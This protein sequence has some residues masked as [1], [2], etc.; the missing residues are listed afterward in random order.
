MLNPRHTVAPPWHDFT[1]LWG[2]CRGGGMGAMSWP[3]AGG[4][5]DQAA[6]IV[7]AFAILASLD[8]QLDRHKRE[9]GGT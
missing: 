2:M 7:D 9:M 8:A 3:D 4:V 5:A 1:R 6:W